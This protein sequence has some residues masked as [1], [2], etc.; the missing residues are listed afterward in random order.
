VF[1]FQPD[2]RLGIA[3]D[4]RARMQ[5]QA[6]EWGANHDRPPAAHDAALTTALGGAGIAA[7]APR[8]SPRSGV[9]SWWPFLFG[10]DHPAG[11]GRSRIGADPIPT[12]P[13][14]EGAPACLPHPS[15]RPSLTSR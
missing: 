12:A 13:L 9:G 4:R 8:R 10:R 2:D 11:Q 7:P 5:H 3:H 15:C 1:D 6:A 14:P